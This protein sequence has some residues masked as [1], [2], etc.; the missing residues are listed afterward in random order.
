MMEISATQ[1]QKPR[2]FVMMLKTVYTTSFID[3]FK[4]ML[5]NMQRSL[6]AALR[7]A[8]VFMSYSLSSRSVVNRSGRERSRHGTWNKQTNSNLTD[9]LEMNLHLHLQLPKLHHTIMWNAN[10]MQQSAFY[11]ISWGR[12]TVK[13][14]SSLHHIHYF[15][16]I[17]VVTTSQYKLQ[18]LFCCTVF[19]PQHITLRN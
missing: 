3:I 14:P 8:T 17:Y 4:F 15:K 16:E 11:I 19:W 1:L 6:A 5:R 18:Y 13:Q 10:L 9:W 12:C 7:P 2:K